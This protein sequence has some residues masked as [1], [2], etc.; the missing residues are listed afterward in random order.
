MN[1]LFQFVA[2]LSVISLFGCPYTSQI[3][4]SEP[5]TKMDKRLLG[6]YQTVEDQAI[7]SKAFLEIEEGNV[8]SYRVSDHKFNSTDSTFTVTN[9]VAYE[10]RI[11]DV[12]FFNVLE[13]GKAPYMIYRIDN[14]SGNSFRLMEVT[15]NIDEKFETSADLAAFLRKYKDV[16]FLYSKEETVYRRMTE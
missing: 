5:E 14:I 2:L 3:P 15:D 12:S 7:E 6:K 13:E 1:K 8:T 10:S 9:Y 4:I 16:S 11:D